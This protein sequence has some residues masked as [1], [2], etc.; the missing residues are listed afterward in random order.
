M[1]NIVKKAFR[2]AKKDAEDKQVEK[3]KKVIQATLEKLESKKKQMAILSKEIKVLKKDIDDFREGRLDKVEERQKKDKEAAEI[4]VVKVI[5]VVEEVREDW[6]DNY[7]Y[8][9]YRFE[10]TTGS[11]NLACNT[12]NLVTGV[13]AITSDYTVDASSGITVCNSTVANATSGTYKLSD[14]TIKYID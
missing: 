10:W 4:S 1:E 5:K 2:E 14:G 11:E 6:K 12:V 9:P 7:W 8:C 3:I 13:N